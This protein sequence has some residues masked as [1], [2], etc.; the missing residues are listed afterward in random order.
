MAIQIPT[1]PYNPQ[2]APGV[3]RIPSPTTSGSGTSPGNGT[4]PASSGFNW[5]SPRRIT[6]DLVISRLLRPSL[7]SHFECSINPPPAPEIQI[8]RAHV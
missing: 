8:G 4:T 2:P 1:I 3:P 5:A 6:N 7:T